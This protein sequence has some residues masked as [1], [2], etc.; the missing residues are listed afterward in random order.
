[1][2]MT[3]FKNL[4]AATVLVGVYALAGA[5]TAAS[6][7]IKDVSSAATSVKKPDGAG[8]MKHKPAVKKKTAARTVTAKKRLSK[9]K[10]HVKLGSAR[11]HSGSTDKA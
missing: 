2:S 8:V 10:P 6:G 7:P 1:M 3:P 11:K 4:I 9:S 5:Q